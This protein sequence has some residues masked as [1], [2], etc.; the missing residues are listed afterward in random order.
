MKLKDLLQEKI[1]EKNPIYQPFKAVVPS[2]VQLL[3]SQI[4]ITCPITQ[5]Q[6]SIFASQFS[7]HIYDAHIYVPV[8]I[9]T[10]GQHKVIYL[11]LGDQQPLGLN[12][13]AMLYLVK[14]K[15]ADFSSRFSQYL[16][17]ALMST[18]IGIGQLLSENWDVEDDEPKMLLI[19]LTGI[20]SENCDIYFKLTSHSLNG[21]IVEKSG[22]LYHAKMDQN[23]KTIYDSG[24]CLMLT[25]DDL[26]NSTDDGENILNLQVTIY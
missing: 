13:C 12:K 10:P 3:K 20:I 4:T 14:G 8:E 18:Y 11:N 24:M 19:W 25:E 6:K 2:E 22:K 15:K 21:L 7:Q 16:P 26:N 9:L 17:V 1:A 5:C 23:F